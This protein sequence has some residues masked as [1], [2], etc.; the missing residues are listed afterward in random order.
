MILYYFAFQKCEQ[1]RLTLVLRLYTSNHSVQAPRRACKWARH[2]ILRAQG[3]LRARPQDDIVFLAGAS[4]LHPALQVQTQ[5]FDFFVHFDISF[6]RIGVCQQPEGGFLPPF[7]MSNFI[8]AQ[9]M[10]S[11]RYNS[12]KKCAKVSI[13]RSK[14]VQ[15]LKIFA[16][17]MC[18]GVDKT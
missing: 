15:K 10:C 6:F 16:H 9:N 11:Y 1:L 12:L 7:L 13:I 8:F 17:K 5:L 2:E 18:K 14:N 4:P 3:G